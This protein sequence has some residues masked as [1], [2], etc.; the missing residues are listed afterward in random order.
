MQQPCCYCLNASVCD[1]FGHD[2]DLSYHGLILVDDSFRVFF[3]SGDNK[4]TGFVFDV[5]D[6]HWCCD[7]RTLI[8]RFCPFCGR[9]L[10]ENKK[11]IKE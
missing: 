1:D 11:F 7:V 10:V 9:E 3:R 8:P 4:P 2:E 6:G 5:F